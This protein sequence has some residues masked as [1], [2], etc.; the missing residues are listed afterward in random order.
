MTAGVECIRCEYCA[1]PLGTPERLCC[2]G[3][4]TPYSIGFYRAW[5]QGQRRLAAGEKPPYPGDFSGWC[6]G[7][8]LPHHDDI[9]RHIREL[10]NVRTGP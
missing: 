8:W 6:C 9:D 1:G 7:R 4:W 5:V 3:E 10:H 2:E